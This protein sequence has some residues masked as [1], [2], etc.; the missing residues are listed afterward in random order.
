MKKF[1][2]YVSIILL[3]TAGIAVAADDESWVEFGGDYQ[4]RYDRLEGKV[5]QHTEYLFG[6]GVEAHDVWNNSLWTNRFR[7]NMK[8]NPLEDITFKVRLTTFKLWGH[9]TTDPMTN[10]YFGMPGFMQPLFDGAMGYVP[11]GSE[12]WVDQAY[13]TWANVFDSP[14]WFSIG[15]RPSTNGVPSNVR[16]NT[17]KIGTAGVP[18]NLIDSGFDGL[19]I[20]F[21]PE[22]E[23]LPGF[24]VKYC[25]G[26]GMT[27]GYAPYPE[28]TAI[29]KD[30][31]FGGLMSTIY[32]TPDLHIEALI[33]YAKH[34]M[35]APPDGMVVL[36]KVWV[37]NAE[38]GDIYWWGVTTMGK[39]TENLNLFLSVGENFWDPSANYKQDFK[40]GML[41]NATT[42]ETAAQR[43]RHT[44]LGLYAGAR[45]DLPSK[46]KLGFEY[47][48]GT[49]YWMPYG[50]ASNDMWTNKLNT[51]G[52]VYEFYVIQ[53]L[54]DKPVAKRGKAFFRVGFQ[55]YD[56]DYTGSLNWLEVPVPMEDLTTNDAQGYGQTFLVPIKK[57]T[58]LYATFEVLF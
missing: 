23:A 16:V 2:L 43:D 3:L 29:P 52:Q 13:A 50:A 20:G 58:D 36:D 40:M 37:S 11:G 21:A 41:W 8:A 1:L 12:V 53:E 33:M 56:F 10:L 30:T 5:N 42:E 17:E 24:Y 25:G 22:I 45:Y 32:D 34:M 6:K 19:T 14:F 15:R 57:A 35:S 46:T 39:P 47:N 31:N 28:F 54:N 18:G 38:V 9:Q 27:R 49:K 51:R 55:Y 44:G 4:L 26:K 48:M 7:I